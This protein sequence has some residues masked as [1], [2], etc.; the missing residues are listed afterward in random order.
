[1]W[2]NLWEKLLND[3]NLDNIDINKIMD[4]NYIY[5]DS[6][7]DFINANKNEYEI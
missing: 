5:E 4:N 1:M 3:N 2:K 7:L 6:K